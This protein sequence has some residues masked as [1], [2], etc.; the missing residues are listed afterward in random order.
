VEGGGRNPVLQ[1]TRWRSSR[2]L[3][4]ELGARRRPQADTPTL[5]GLQVRD[6]IWALPLGSAGGGSWG[7]VERYRRASVQK[8]IAQGGD[9]R[10]AAGRRRQLGARG[11][12]IPQRVVEVEVRAPHSPHR[13]LPGPPC[14][15]SPPEGP[16]AVKGATWYAY[17]RAWAANREESGWGNNSNADYVGDWSVQKGRTRQRMYAGL[18]PRLILG[19]V[20]GLTYQEAT[21]EAPDRDWIKATAG[22]EPI[23]LARL[24]RKRPAM[25]PALPGHPPAHDG[26]APEPGERP[27]AAESQPASSTSGSAVPRPVPE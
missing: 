17:R 5:P 25:P 9:L 23:D 8:I 6:G 26:T 16:G 14:H 22:V 7:S 13:G 24:A 11:R 12:R 3:S 21:D 15:L 10:A 2:P 18:S 20:F 4:G 19:V 1:G 27:P